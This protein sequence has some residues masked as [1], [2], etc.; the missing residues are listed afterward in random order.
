MLT[1]RI[2]AHRAGAGLAPE[3]TLAAI[4]EAHAL[5]V[6]WVEMDVSLMGDGTLLIWHDRSFDRCSNGSGLLNEMDYKTAQKFDAGSWFASE[7]ST[8]RPARLN[9]VL[10]LLEM[11]GMGLN[12]EVKIHNGEENTT[13]VA[14]LLETIDRCWSRPDKLLVSSFSIPFIR[15]L[16][17]QR[18][19]LHKGL[20]F[21][22]LPEEWAYYAEELSARSINL[23]QADLTREQAEAVKSA[24]YELYLW[25]VNDQESADMFWSW[26]V[27][28][29]IT[30]VPDRLQ[31]F[32]AGK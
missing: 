27:D 4:R 9:R 29:I 21:E 23:G 19:S 32:A 24:G 12:L 25:T 5:G 22:R 30:D 18:A 20:L 14:P 15:E 26:G 8:E 13:M 17:A 10:M 1:S 31:F 16:H 7:F 6:E 11:L 3:N 2:I 28:G